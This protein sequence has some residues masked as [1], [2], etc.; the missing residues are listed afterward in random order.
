MGTDAQRVA[1][2]HQA[3][4]QQAPSVSAPSPQVH[5]VQNWGAQGQNIGTNYP[6]TIS[7]SVPG[8]R[9][10]VPPPGAGTFVGAPHQGHILPAASTPAAVP[11]QMLGNPSAKITAKGI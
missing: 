11:A 7:Q 10:A 5:Q 3:A 8:A 9:V 4:M 6:A 1:A 2:M